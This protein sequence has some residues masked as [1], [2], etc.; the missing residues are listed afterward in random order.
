MRTE[1]YVK[2]GI[3]LM[4]ATLPLFSTLILQSGPVAPLQATV[5]A[6]STLPGDSLCATRPF[7]LGE[8]ACG[9]AGHRRSI[10]ASPLPSPS[11]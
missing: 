11:A 6:V 9:D 8:A 3:V 10:Q 4:G 1:F 7:K 2:T 5:I